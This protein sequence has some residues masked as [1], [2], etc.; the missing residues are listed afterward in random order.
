MAAQRP[1]I[2]GPA[3]NIP[4]YLLVLELLIVRG[5]TVHYD[6]GTKLGRMEAYTIHYPRQQGP[7]LTNARMMFPDARGAKQA[8][9]LLEE[10]NAPDIYAEMAAGYAK[11]MA[12]SMQETCNTVFQKAFD[13]GYNK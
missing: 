4:E 7:K 6:D 11:S 9:E 10:L 2:P 3:A 8:L 13:E 5:C 1:D 12:K